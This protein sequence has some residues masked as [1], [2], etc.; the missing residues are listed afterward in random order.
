MLKS[1]AW[2]VGLYEH[3]TGV[4]HLRTTDAEV[5]RGDGAAGEAR[6]HYA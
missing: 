1:V 2:S 3:S 4:A 6:W 5:A